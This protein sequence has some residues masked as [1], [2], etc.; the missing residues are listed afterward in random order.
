MKEGF[1][2][3]YDIYKTARQIELNYCREGEDRQT[4]DTVKQTP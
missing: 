4:T 2:I 1:R 3:S